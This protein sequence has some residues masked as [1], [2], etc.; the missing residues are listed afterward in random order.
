[1]QGKEWSKSEL[2]YLRR[3]YGRMTASQ[4]GKILNKSE[5]AIRNAASKY[6]IARQVETNLLRNCSGCIFLGKLGSGENFCNYLCIM[7]ERRDCE[8][9]NCNK[10]LTKK[11][12]DKAFLKKVKEAKEKVNNED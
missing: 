10:K 3:N 6:K 8:V 5:Y 2:D 4:I 12:V 7:G 1:M 11:E 9:L